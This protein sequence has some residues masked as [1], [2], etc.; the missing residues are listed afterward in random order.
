MLDLTNLKANNNNYQS[1]SS[2]K[3]ETQTNLVGQTDF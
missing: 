2:E 1:L 3:N